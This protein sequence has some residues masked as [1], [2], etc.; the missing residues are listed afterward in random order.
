GP[1][2]KAVGTGERGRGEGSRKT[3]ASGVDGER[4]GGEQRLIQVGSWEFE[5][6]DEE[7]MKFLELFLSYV[8]ER[9]GAVNESGVV[10]LL[11]GYGRRLR[12]QEL[13]SLAFHVQSSLKRRQNRGRVAQAI[14]TATGPGISLAHP[15]QGRH[16]GCRQTITTAAISTVPNPL[17]SSIRAQ[18]SAHSYFPA[19]HARGRGGGCG[20]FGSRSSSL[21]APADVPWQWGAESHHQ[22]GTDPDPAHAPSYSLTPASLL[23]PGLP[24][25]PSQLDSEPDPGLEGSCSDTAKLLEWMVRW[26]E[27]R[28]V[29]GT[30]GT[31]TGPGHGP[32][33]R[34]HTSVTAILHSLRLLD[35]S[36][37][38]DTAPRKLSKG[39]EDEKAVERVRKHRQPRKRWV[40]VAVS[41]VC[42]RTDRAT[43]RSESAGQLQKQD[44]GDTNLCSGQDLTSDSDSESDE[45]GSR[46]GHRHSP[47][48]HGGYVSPAA[49]AACVDQEPRPRTPIGPGISITVH[50][51]SRTRIRGRVTEDSDSDTE[52]P[53]DDSLTSDPGGCGDG[54]ISTDPGELVDDP[55]GTDDWER[56]ENATERMENP[57]EKTDNPR[58]RT[59]NP[60]ER[61]NNSGDG[62][63]SVDEPITIEP[64]QRLCGQQRES[65]G[66]GQAASSSPSV[67]PPGLM[68]TVAP[69][70]LPAARQTTLTSDTDTHLLHHEV[71]K[72]L[73]LQQ[74]GFLSLMQVLGPSLM[75]AAAPQLPQSVPGQAPVPTPRTDPPPAGQEP[76]SEEQERD[77]VVME[78]CLLPQQPSYPPE[79]QVTQLRVPARFPMGRG[80]EGVCGSR[81]VPAPATRPDPQLLHHPAR[82]HP[83]ASSSHPQLPLPTPDSHPNLL[84]PPTL[85][86]L[87]HPS[88]PTLLPLAQ[89]SQ[90][91]LF[92]LRETPVIS[93]C[94]QPQTQLLHPLRLIPAGDVI[95]FERSGLHRAQRSPGQLQAR[96]L[97]LLTMRLPAFQPATQRD[98]K[99]RVRRRESRRV[100]MVCKRET[101]LPTTEAET[102]TPPQPP[103]PRPHSSESGD[104]V[105]LT[106]PAEGGVDPTGPSAPILSA[107]AAGSFAAATAAELHCLAATRKNAAERRDAS[108]NTE[109]MSQ[110][111]KQRPAEPRCYRDAGTVTNP[112]T[113]E[114]PVTAGT[115]ELRATGHPWAPPL[116]LHTGMELLFPSDGCPEPVPTPTP[117]QVLP[118]HSFLTVIDVAAGELLN[119]LPSTVAVNECR[120]SPRAQSPSTAALHLRAATVIS[121]DRPHTSPPPRSPAAASMQTRLAAWEQQ[122]PEDEE[123][124]RLLQ[125]AARAWSPRPVSTHSLQSSAHVYPPR[126]VSASA[127]QEGSAH[128]YPPRPVS[129]SALQEGSAHVY[130]PR[131]VSASALQEGNAIV[132]PPRPVSASAL[133]IVYPPRPN[134]AHF[135]L[136]D[137]ARAQT[138]RPASTHSLQE[139]SAHVYPPCPA[140]THSLWTIV[141]VPLPLS[142][143]LWAL[144][145]A[146]GHS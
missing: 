4:D 18:G 136:Q 103:D 122:Q 133:P 106:D 104:M 115:A 6:G 111:Q 125:D 17:H 138:P 94:H 57:R 124:C 113:E 32:A 131:P 132:Y 87:A 44:S 29:H 20:L 72:L 85:L 126:P 77:A 10:P 54:S 35:R 120:A 34:V 95:G 108:T 49:A 14:G 80:D 105:L 46:Y 9:D 82:Q 75:P 28:P 60:R 98:G 56:T 21:S 145:S 42:S 88:Q 59:D 127:L 140:S 24:A 119:Q 37:G 117:R 134:S 43:L 38:I 7:Y 135:V 144:L 12:E 83:P 67:P 16:L 89:F 142:L 143:S 64:S 27:R 129:A 137:V 52:E 74:A 79:W 109:R 11:S 69:Q 141:P 55:D 81:D 100:E 101:E 97:H 128:V 51:N 19:N 121:G 53:L 90:P 61:T 78:S 39:A 25:A 118:G 110:G 47:Q 31:G 8:L 5:C 112:D 84:L 73:Q 76:V 26:S 86:P 30:H 33:I 58:E 50:T 13:D 116:L 41:G 45:E 48:E 22:P 92:P 96:A 62:W 107:W 68:P 36:L 93:F 114:Q 71:F 3:S 63:E 91:T 139:G 15:P 66:P 123:T 130:P 65:P 99:K 102:P 23:T 1:G 2:V 70:S 146:R 40:G